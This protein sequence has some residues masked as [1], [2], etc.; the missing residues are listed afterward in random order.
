MERIRVIEIPPLTV[1]NSGNISSMEDFEAF[2]QWWSSV[3]VKH[4]I[5]PR[6]F[7]WYNVKK[8]YLEWFFALPE[9]YKD[10]GGYEVADFPGGLYAVAT[11]KDAEEVA[12]QET[13]ASIRAWVETSGCFEIS[14]SENDSA[15]RYEMTHVTT[16]KVFKEKMGYHLSDIFV[17]IVAK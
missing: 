11:S 12:I 6:D 3:D 4:Y 14:T 15:E 7:M 17:P 5:T 8:G 1:V 2:D 10:T 16:P 9:G 13:K